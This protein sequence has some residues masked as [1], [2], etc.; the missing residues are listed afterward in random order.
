MGKEAGNLMTYWS[1]PEESQKENSPF[2]FFQFHAFLALFIKWCYCILN[3]HDTLV[4]PHIAWTMKCCEKQKGQQSSPS[5]VSADVLLCAVWFN[6]LLAQVP[7]SLRS[8]QPFGAF[9][10]HWILKN[11]ITC[12]RVTLSYFQVTYPNKTE[13]PRCQKLAWKTSKLYVNDQTCQN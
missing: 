11:G 3:V 8:I 1:R 2:I 4:E 10:E 5:S 7:N 12:S 9:Y 6:D 13:Q